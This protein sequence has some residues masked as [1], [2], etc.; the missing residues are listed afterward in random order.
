[1]P[2]DS[3]SAEEL[4]QI[5]STLHQ[6][7][8]EAKATYDTA[9]VQVARLNE[10]VLDLGLNHPD[11]MAAMRNATSIQRRALAV[12]MEAM[13]RFNDFVLRYKVPRDL[14]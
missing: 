11:G 10:T 1:M 6:Q 8:T 14:A 5:E 12:Y 9:K 13:R 7:L 4:V 3:P 2:L